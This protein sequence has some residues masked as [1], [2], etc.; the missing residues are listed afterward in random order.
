MGVGRQ[1]EKAMFV[2]PCNRAK[3]S[4]I[5]IYLVLMCITPNTPLSCISYRAGAGTQT[6]LLLVTALAQV[7]AKSLEKGLWLLAWHLFIFLNFLLHWVDIIVQFEVKW[8]GTSMLCLLL[9]HAS[10]PC[11]AGAAPSHWSFLRFNF[12]SR[13]GA[14]ER[15][16]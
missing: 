7:F 12:C 16:I 6:Q 13:L 14:K 15:V 1:A 10:L 3:Q 2:S 8:E 5:M 9:F 4:V 11:L